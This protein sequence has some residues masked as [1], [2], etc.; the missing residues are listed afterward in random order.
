MKSI[1]YVAI[2]ITCIVGIGYALSESED[3]EGATT[4]PTNATLVDNI[5]YSIWDGEA[6]VRGPSS[7]NLSSIT[8][9]STVTIDGQTYTVTGI[10]GTQGQDYPGAF[11]D[12][13]SLT[14]VTLPYTIE[15]FNAQYDVNS[16][17]YTYS[18]AFA[19]MYS[20]D[21]VNSNLTTVNWNIPEGES[22]HLT[23]VGPGAFQNCRKL[24]TFD[25]P[26]SVTTIGTR[27]FQSCYVYSI[28]QFP[29]ALT[30]I[31]A[32]AFSGDAITV[33][34]VPQTVVYIGE[35]AF[36]NCTSIT[37]FT[38]PDTV[39]NL[40]PGVFGGCT[41]LQSLRFPAGMTAIPSRFCTDCTNL[42][43]VT[44]P[45]NYT[46]VG[47][48]AFMNCSSLHFAL[49]AGL[50]SVGSYAFKGCTSMAISSIP[51][52]ITTIESYAFNGAMAGPRLVIPATVTTI[53]DYAFGMLRENGQICTHPEIVFEGDG[54]IGSSTNV[55]AVN[56]NRIFQ[57]PFPNDSYPANT[58]VTIYLYGKTYSNIYYAIYELPAVINNYSSTYINTRSNLTINYYAVYGNVEYAL[59]NVLP[60]TSN[61]ATATVLGLADDSVTSITIPSSFTYYSSRTCN[62][63]GIMGSAT[64]SGLGAFGGT[65]LVSVN[66]R[67]FSLNYLYNPNGSNFAYAN[68]FKDCVN[69]TTVTL[70]SQSN[71]AIPAGMFY[72]CTSLDITNLVG[73][74]HIGKNSFRDCTSLTLSNTD[75]SVSKK[76]VTVGDHAF[77]GCIQ[78]DPIS[79]SFANNTGNVGDYAFAGCVSLSPSYIFTLGANTT[80]GDHAFDGCIA[81][82]DDNISN[83]TLGDYTFNGCTA[84][85]PT[86]IENVTTG[87]FTFNGCTSLNPTTFNN[88]S[89]GEGAF[90]NCTGLETITMKGTIDLGPAVF[91]LTDIEEPTT[92]ERSLAL[93]FMTDDVDYTETTFASVGPNSYE[94]IYNI[95]DMGNNGF[96]TASSGLPASATVSNSLNLESIR[97]IQKIE[98]EGK[99][100]G[101]DGGVSA[102]IINLLPVFVAIGLILA[103]ISMF[104]DPK[105]LIG[106]Q[107]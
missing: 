19:I 40:D 75:W 39:T 105:N 65:G 34:T 2:L 95:V 29:S 97:M 102:T 55:V 84:L 60:N 87:D 36:Y 8:I 12:M 30:S 35:N 51:S 44:M 77:D 104:Y 9:P 79:L 32:Y 22:C 86:T 73:A 76:L 74:I 68:T 17:N 52:G 25:I 13:F 94:R 78:L 10:A 56:G 11:S 107:Q 47:S 70:P 5:W 85:N 15:S 27:A 45:T 49:P 91:N 90:Q 92:E 41:S 26:D 1:V 81:L 89:V 31:G 59:T 3:T 100:G 57:E 96:T 62:V 4:N 6:I 48:N 98:V 72:G 23:S 38:L 63:A 80:F 54:A 14:T 101:G 50:T 7:A 21:A 20:S 64:E 46:A 18:N 71:Y 33:S 53:G 66:I 37:Q 69:L 16:A 61:P 67:S 42:A 43:T 93:L 83:V 24:A 99:E 82:N 103:M 106:G 58:T 88:V 28:S